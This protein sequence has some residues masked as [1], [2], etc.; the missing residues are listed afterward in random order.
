MTGCLVLTGVHDLDV[1][2]RYASIFFFS[3]GI[4]E[5]VNEAINSFS[6]HSPE[7]NTPV[8][9]ESVKKKQKRKKKR[10]QR[11]QTS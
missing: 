10:N 2:A 8:R 11:N 6:C 4:S 9:Q 7:H 1:I 5:N 3:Y